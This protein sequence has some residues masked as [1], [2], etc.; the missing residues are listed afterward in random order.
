MNLGQGSSQSLGLVIFFAI[1]IHK[2]PASMGLGSYLMGCGVENYLSHILSFTLSSPL[3][4]ILTFVLL[5]TLSVDKKSHETIAFHIGVLL[6]ISA[7]TF[8]HVSTVLILPAV[9]PHD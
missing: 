6:L 2:I 8:L 7:G 4:N 9:D 1:L 3:F 5:S